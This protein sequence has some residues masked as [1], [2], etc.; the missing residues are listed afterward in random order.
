MYTVVPGR[1]GALK[2]TVSGTSVI[3][4]WAPPTNLNGGVLKE[5]QVNYYGYEEEENALVKT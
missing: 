1:P 2:V 5:Y 4:S 3:L